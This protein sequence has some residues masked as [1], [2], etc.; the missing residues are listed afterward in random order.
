[1]LLM[2]LYSVP[3]KRISNRHPPNYSITYPKPKRTTSHRELINGTKEDTDEQFNSAAAGFIR[4]SYGTFTEDKM[5]RVNLFLGTHNR[6]SARQASA[7]H[8]ELKRSNTPTIPVE[9]GQLLG[10][11]DEVSCELVQSGGQEGLLQSSSTSNPAEGDGK[12][13][14]GE[15]PR[16][17]KCLSW[18]TVGECVSYLLRRAVENRDAVERT[19]DGRIELQ[20]EV[21]RRF[22]GVFGFGR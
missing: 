17:Y 10:M 15:A 21:W 7:L 5:P 9:Y 6:E 13:V 8:R 11:A 3:T 2:P 14:A 19:R 1:M 4:R 20:K 22:K 12:N 16:V 18:G